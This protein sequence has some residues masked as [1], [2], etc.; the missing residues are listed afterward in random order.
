MCSPNKELRYASV[1]DRYS[2][3]VHFRS[4]MIQHGITEDRCIARNKMVKK[5]VHML[6]QFTR[7]HAGRVLRAV[8]KSRY[9]KVPMR[10][11]KTAIIIEWR[12]R[13]IRDVNRKHIR[14]HTK[15]C[16]G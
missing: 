2:R 11:T 7:G 13:K 3:D 1:H 16:E 8:A 6:H 9:S 14:R 15:K 10:K 4:R 12:W 5:V